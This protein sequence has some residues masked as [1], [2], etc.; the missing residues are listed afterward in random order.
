MTE[1]IWQKF[2]I[3]KKCLNRK[4]GKNFKFLNSKMD[5]INGEVKEEKSLHKTLSLS[6]VEQQSSIIILPL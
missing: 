2:Y 3:F 6:S 1:K 4:L 5:T